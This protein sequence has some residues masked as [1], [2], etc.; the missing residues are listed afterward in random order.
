MLNILEERTPYTP[1]MVGCIHYSKY[2]RTCS[3]ILDVKGSVITVLDCFGEV[4]HGND[5]KVRVHQTPL[6]Y[7]DKVMTANEFF[8]A[9]SP[10]YGDEILTAHESC[11]KSVEDAEYSR[12]CIEELG[13]DSNFVCVGQDDELEFHPDVW[14][15]IKETFDEYKIE[16]YSLASLTSV[17]IAKFSCDLVEID[18]YNGNYV[19]QPMRTKDCKYPARVYYVQIKG[20]KA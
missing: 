4:N 16:R 10:Y 15:S 8:L 11:L 19:L 9:T 5:H 12:L 18:T 20:N 7:G 14:D 2:W 3:L 13:F 6:H 17:L 1:D